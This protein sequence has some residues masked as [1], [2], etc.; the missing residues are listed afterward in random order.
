MNSG[1]SPEKGAPFFEAV[2]Q[3]IGGFLVELAT[4]DTEDLYE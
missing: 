3:Q 1:E 4:A 2:T